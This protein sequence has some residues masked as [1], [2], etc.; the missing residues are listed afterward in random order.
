MNQRLT[1]YLNGVFTPYDGVKS[2]TELK[3]DLLS[4]LQ[5]RYSELRAEG[6]DDETA[7]KMTIDSIGDIEE[8]ILEVANLS[9]SLERQVQVNLHAIDLQ[10][11][12]FAGV[13]LHKGKFKASALRGADF[14]GADLTGSS[15][16]TSDARE[17]NFDSA[18][19]TDCTLSTLDLTNASFH[20]TILDRTHFSTSGLDGAIFKDV[21]LT[22]VTLTKTDLRKTSFENCIFNGVDFK[23]CD[24]RGNCF[25]GQTFIG[26]KFDKSALNDVSFRGATLKNVTFRL[27]FSVTNKSYLAFKTVCFDGATMDKLTYAALKGL[28]VVDLS[29]VTVM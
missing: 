26:V 5:E 22:D 23:Y 3:A 20:K 17:A 7:F 4:D 21:K 12:D 8:T 6:N 15:F 28:W 29:K 9:R 10:E 11:S 18:N 16:A 24:L 14:T 2:V 13:I 1:D 19:L 25:D 27:P